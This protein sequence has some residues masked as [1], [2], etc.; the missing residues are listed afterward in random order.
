MCFYTIAFNFVFISNKIVVH[1]NAV[2]FYFT[3]TVLHII[4]SVH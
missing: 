4:A 1:T 2:S 3:H